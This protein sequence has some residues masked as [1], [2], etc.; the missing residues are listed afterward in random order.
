M[1][2]VLP[3]APLPSDPSFH[4][5]HSSLFSPRSLV[6][7]RSLS[8]SLSLFSRGHSVSS[9]AT[10]LRA[11]EWRLSRL[12]RPYQRASALPSS[13]PACFPAYLPACFPAC[14][15]SCLFAC[16]PTYL[17]THLPTYLPACLPCLTLSPLISP[18]VSDSASKP[19]RML[20]TDV[21]HFPHSLSLTRG[22]SSFPRSYFP[23]LPISPCFLSFPLPGHS[24]M[25]HHENHSSLSFLFFYLSLVDFLPPDSP[26]MARLARGLLPLSFA[27]FFT[28][29]F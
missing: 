10:P 14:L 9:R 13:L 4:D 21:H 5:G 12:A 11:R 3:Q 20:P 22:A 24:L 1:E 27:G 26:L 19:P 17:P 16:L 8:H 15:F 18:P 25:H 7:S 29:Y 6:H 2:D 28:G 23:L